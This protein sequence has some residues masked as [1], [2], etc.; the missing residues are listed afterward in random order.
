MNARTIVR[1]STPRDVRQTTWKV[2]HSLLFLTGSYYHTILQRSTTAAD[3]PR[4]PVTTHIMAIKA[5][6]QQQTLVQ[7][8]LETTIVPILLYSKTLLLF[9]VRD[10]LFFALGCSF[11]L[12]PM[13]IRKPKHTR[14]YF[15][16]TKGRWAQP[17]LT[18]SDNSLIRFKSLSIFKVLVDL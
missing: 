4:A 5:G 11:W 6:A 2:V 16:T 13:M 8:T 9:C 15:G 18:G 17:S 3:L 7:Q 10:G 1:F 12:G 14:L